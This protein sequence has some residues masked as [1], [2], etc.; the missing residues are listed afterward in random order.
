VPPG[1]RPADLR[2]PAPDP[3][4]GGRPYPRVRLR[5]RVS[6]RGRVADRSV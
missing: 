3:G 6:L 2:E 4:S 1:G 5:Q